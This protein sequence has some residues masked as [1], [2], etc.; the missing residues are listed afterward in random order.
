M[1][2]SEY[3]CPEEIFTVPQDISESERYDSACLSLERIKGTVLTTAQLMAS[4]SEYSP[5]AVRDC[6][7]GVYSQL[8]ILEKLVS[9]QCR[10]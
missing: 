2:H 6:L 9:H 10:R 7:Y 8:E 3:N 1:S 5:D 4:R